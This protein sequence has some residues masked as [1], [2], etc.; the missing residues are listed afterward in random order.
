MTW[1]VTCVFGSA[2]PSPS[3]L[4]EPLRLGVWL[5]R[6]QYP[7]QYTPSKGHLQQIINT[8]PEDPPVIP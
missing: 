4:Y 2:G 3:H 6:G 1:C 8:S 7:L 5:L